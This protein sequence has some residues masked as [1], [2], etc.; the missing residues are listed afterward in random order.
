MGDSNQG[1]ESR[2]QEAE[3]ARAKKQS[4]KRRAGS[5]KRKTRG[6]RNKAMVQLQSSVVTSGKREEMENVEEATSQL[7]KSLDQST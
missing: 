7:Q 2:Q 4:R 3:E 6:E 5:K 1:T